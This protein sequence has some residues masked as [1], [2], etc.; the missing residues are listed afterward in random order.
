MRC[1]GLK[2]AMAPRVALCLGQ[3]REAIRE[4]RLEPDVPPGNYSVADKRDALRLILSDHALI[5]EF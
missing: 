2:G 3:T 4:T 1:A 5:M